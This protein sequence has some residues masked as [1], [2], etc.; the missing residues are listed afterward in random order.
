MSL[1]DLVPTWTL[2]N[3]NG[4][5]NGGSIDLP[6]SRYA[7]VTAAGAVEVRRVPDQVLLFSLPAREAPA[8]LPQDFSPDGKFLA[9]CYT[10]SRVAV[11]DLEQRQAVVEDLGRK[12]R[13]EIVAFTSDS[14]RVAIGGVTPVVSI[15][16]LAARRLVCTITNDSSTDALSFDS[17]GKRIAVAL[18]DS[19]TVLIAD[20]ETGAILSRIEHPN[21]VHRP[22]WHPSHPLV[23]VG[24]SDGMVYFW[25]PE[26]G[27]RTG[28]TPNDSGE[29]GGVTFSHRGDLMVSATWNRL[30]FWSPN[31]A[32]SLRADNPEP[33]S[34]RPTFRG[35]GNGSMVRFDASDRSLSRVFWGMPQPKLEIDAI[36]SAPEVR[37]FHSPRPDSFGFVRFSLNQDGTLGLLTVSNAVQILDVETGVELAR[38]PLPGALEALFL[39][40]TAGIV[41]TSDEGMFL[42]SFSRL[43]DHNRISIAPVRL[44]DASKG[45]KRVRLGPGGDRLAMWHEDH[46]RIYSV[47]DFRFI[48]RTGNHNGGDVLGP[49]F[50]ADEQLLA[51]CR[52]NNEHITI[53]NIAASQSAADHPHQLHP[54]RDPRS[55]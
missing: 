7:L 35:V 44:I 40:D 2:E 45:L 16:D 30:V 23:A 53:W 17:S 1:P 39:P 4:A 32:L 19:T 25:N 5:W 55:R 14:S 38:L 34:L 28:S 50:S 9:I 52:W 10:N 54:R 24:C 51:I 27:Q 22:D 49:S 15:W 33:A 37:V 13:V 47:P 12:L 6:R 11:W 8:H 36:S 46:A 29:C 26:S 31:V 20:A 3:S 43:D 48:S 21:L 18:Y 42:W 41:A